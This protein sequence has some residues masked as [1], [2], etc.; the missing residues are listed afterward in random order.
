VA[1]L[2]TDYH[3]S[4]LSTDSA[5]TNWN[6]YDNELSLVVRSDA[7]M[8]NFVQARIIYNQVEIGY[9]LSGVY[10]RIGSPA[11]VTTLKSGDKWEFKAGTG[12]LLDQPYT[13]VLYQNDNPV[14]TVVDSSHAS[15]KGA[16]YRYVG[17]IGVAG[18]QSPY[19][20]TY[21]QTPAPDLSVF[22]GTDFTP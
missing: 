20:F 19:F 3:L 14:L 10:T 8:N 2:S 17:V 18:V 11:S 12:T 6:T 22:A 1:A 15:Q 21:V 16:S 7:A 4:R 5:L 13:F 9:V